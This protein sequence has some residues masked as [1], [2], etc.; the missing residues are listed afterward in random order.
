MLNVIKEAVSL[1]QSLSKISDLVA[2]IGDPKRRR[3][4]KLLLAIEAAD[5]I[6]DIYRREG[7][8]KNMPDKRRDK[9]MRHWTKRW[10]RFRDGI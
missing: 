3:V 4:V 8:Y 10:R 1:F 9:M 5:N 2:A 7:I 6:I